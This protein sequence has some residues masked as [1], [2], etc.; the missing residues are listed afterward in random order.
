MMSFNDFLSF[1]HNC[2]SRHYIFDMCLINGS[3]TAHIISLDSLVTA[4]RIKSD[5]FDLIEI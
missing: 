3:M 2:N 5:F 1:I 4:E